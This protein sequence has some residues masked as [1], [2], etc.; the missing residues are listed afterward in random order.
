MKVSVI[1]P[2]YNVKHYLARCLDSVRY[3]TYHD[4][5]IVMVDDASFDGS[6]AIA[7]QYQK[8]YHNIVLVKHE[9]NQGLMMTRRDGYLAATGELIMFLDSDDA[10]PKDAVEKLFNK[11]VETN[12][13]IVMGDLM[14][15]YVDGTTERVVGS[16]GSDATKIEVLS[17][18]LEQ[19]ITHSLC[20]KL[21]KKNIFE[22][23]HLQTYKSL[24]IAED[25]CLFYQLVDKTQKI[26][27]VQTVVYNYYENKASS[28]LRA[29]GK[30]QIEN[31]IVAYKAIENVCK[32]YGPLRNRLV[33]RLNQV[34]FTLYFERVPI[35][36][37]R[38]LLRKHDMLSYGHIY[39]VI[40]TLK[41]RDYWFCMK[42]FIYVRIKLRK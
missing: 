3:Q 39:N 27:S 42:R 31:V 16:L 26:A 8:Q 37:V 25:G 14:K 34:V 1:I 11:Q 21:Y 35:W 20:G 15:Y 5:E 10:L 13:D 19:R 41:F 40:K 7:E 4:I 33:Y 24:T 6:M 9:R 32:S 23:G 38:K 18:L 17:A 12:A 30:E 2:V 29:Y 36:T 28:T 22:N